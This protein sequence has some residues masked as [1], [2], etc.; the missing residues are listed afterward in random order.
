MSG[1]RVARREDGQ[2]LIELL[3]GVPVILVAALICLQM[4]CF[5]Y[6]QTAVDGAAEAAAIATADGRDPVAATS[7]ALPGWAAS[8]VEVK[9]RS[10]GT[11]TVEVEPRSLLPGL[12]GRLVARA[13]AWVRSGG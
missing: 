8:R 2:A 10:D 3:V 7:A 9:S 4:L 12:D 13:S 5:G 1:H 6:A 11:S